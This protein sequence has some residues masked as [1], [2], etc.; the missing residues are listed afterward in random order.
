[1][2]HARRPQTELDTL[3]LLSIYVL[4][5]IDMSIPAS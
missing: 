4:L 5:F 1:M 2:A 3:L